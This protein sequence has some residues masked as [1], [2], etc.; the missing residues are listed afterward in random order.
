MPRAN[1]FFDNLSETAMLS[2]REAVNVLESY[3]NENNI[4][5]HRLPNRAIGDFIETIRYAPSTISTRDIANATGIRVDNYT[6]SPQHI[7]TSATPRRLVHDRNDVQMVS[8]IVNYTTLHNARIPVASLLDTTRLS[9]DDI[10]EEATVE[11][12]TPFVGYSTYSAINRAPKHKKRTRSEKDIMMEIVRT[13]Q[14]P[15]PNFKDFSSKQEYAKIMDNW[16]SNV[17]YREHWIFSRTEREGFNRRNI[18]QFSLDDVMARISKRRKPHALDSKYSKFYDW[19]LG[20]TDWTLRLELFQ[21]EQYYFLITR[22]IHKPTDTEV[23]FDVRYWSDNKFKPI[24]SLWIEASNKV[25]IFERVFGSA[26]ESS[27][28]YVA[29]YNEDEAEEYHDEY[30]D[31]EYED[32]DDEPCEIEDLWE[33]S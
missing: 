13:A 2:E 4:I 11:H 29:P 26:D 28:Y 1:Q 32:Y 8:G 20:G 7:T 25:D 21:H 5:L 19:K 23:K 22:H 18:G 12:D 30:E 31:N 6:I 33:D 27:P 14:F 16:Y 3:C 24:N 15:R 10:M 9:L 17:E